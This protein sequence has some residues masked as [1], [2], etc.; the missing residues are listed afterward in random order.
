MKASGPERPRRPGSGTPARLLGCL[1]FLL[2]P[3][4]TWA[5]GPGDGAGSAADEE[6]EEVRLREVY[7]PNAEFHASPERDRLPIENVTL[8]RVR[9]ADQSEALVARE[10]SGWEQVVIE[11]WRLTFYGQGR[12]PLRKGPGRQIIVQEWS[13]GAHCCF[14]Y[15]VLHVEGVRVNREGIVRAG[16]CELRVADLAADGALELIACDSRF[17]YAFDLPFADS[18]LVP[19]IYV[20]RDKGLVIENRRFPQ[21]YQFRITQERRRLAEAERTGD[22]RGAR[23]ALISILVHTLYAGRVT[24]AWCGFEKAYR[25]PDRARVRQ[26]VLRRLRLAPDPEEGRIPPV[27][28]AYAATP[29]G[30]CP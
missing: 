29:P 10:D 27:D 1:A 4:A 26:E 6:D 19:M 2:V 16:D 18:P 5:A 15:H 22:A 23:R 24:D 8:I 30:R 25:W 11:G 7:V 14:D 9:R 21:V 13:G 17:A 20:L 28:L 3:L 12:Q